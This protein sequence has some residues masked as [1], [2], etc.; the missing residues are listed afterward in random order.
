MP[1]FVSKCKILTLISFSSLMS[2]KFVCYSLYN[3]QVYFPYHTWV[4]S[5]DS[6]LRILSLS[7]PFQIWM[8]MMGYQLLFYMIHIF[9]IILDPFKLPKLLYFFISTLYLDCGNS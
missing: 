7:S 2:D 4:K 9:G 1:P 6:E 3:I 8:G 5:Y